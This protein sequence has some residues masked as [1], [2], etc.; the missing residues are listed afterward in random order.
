MAIAKHLFNNILEQAFGA[1]NTLF[2]YAT[3]PD[4]ETETGGV[5]LIVTGSEEYKI[6]E[7]DFLIKGGTCTSKRN[8]LL[9]LCNSQPGVSA[10]ATGF[11]IKDT[12]GNL[13]YFGS[14]TNPITVER[15][16]VPTI[17][18]YNESQGEGI[19]VTITSSE[20]G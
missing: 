17:K 20:N 8:I 16:T 7:G 18:V 12:N 14:F 3:V 13:V 2:L 9:Y 19:K 5:P 15:N 6:K 10:V 1:G 4:E 11:G